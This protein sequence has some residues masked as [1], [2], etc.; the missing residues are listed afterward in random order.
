M[1]KTAGSLVL[2]TGIKVSATITAAVTIGAVTVTA[3]GTLNSSARG[4]SLSA[5]AQLNVDINNVIATFLYLKYSGKQL[6]TSGASAPG[7]TGCAKDST[8]EIKV[9]L[10]QHPCK[11]YSADTWLVSKNNISTQVAFSR[12]EMPTTSLARKYKAEVDQPGTGNPPG[13]A[14]DFDGLCYASRRQ[15]T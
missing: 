15:G 6:S 4:S 8:K 13:V 7:A 3:T 12:V 5:S 14:S 1:A 10:T 2:R 11:D 9:F